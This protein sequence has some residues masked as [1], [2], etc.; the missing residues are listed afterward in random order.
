MQAPL[1]VDAALA[2]ASVHRH[3]L[4][5]SLA[6]MSL[7]MAYMFLVMQFGMSSMS[8]PGHRDMDASAASLSGGVGP[9]A[10]VT[11]WPVEP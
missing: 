4:R 2:A 6:A 3:G 7:G 8:M 5:V 10:V 11:A 1:R 9:S